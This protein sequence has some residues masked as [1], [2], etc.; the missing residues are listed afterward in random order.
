MFLNGIPLAAAALFLLLLSSH[1]FAQNCVDIAVST[2]DVMLA[3]NE[4]MADY[5][6]LLNNGSEGTFVIDGVDA[7]ESSAFLSASYV[8]ADST[9]MEPYGS[10]ELTIRLA[11]SSV[12]SDQTTAVTVGVRGHFQGGQSCSS[13]QIQSQFEVQ[14]PDSYSPTDDSQ[15]EEEIAP[16]EDGQQSD[17][18]TQAAVA[19]T[20][21]GESN[22]AVSAAIL[23]ALTVE[24]P[25][26]VFLAKGEKEISIRMTNG[27]ASSADYSIDFIGPVNVSF[28][29]SN[30]TIGAFSTKYITMRVP[31]SASLAG[32]DYEST[33][34]VQS[35]G[36]KIEKKIDV[37]FMEKAA[38]PAP[39]PKKDADD[40]IGSNALVSGFFALFSFDWLGW[41]GW[42]FTPE[43]AL[44]LA[45]ALIAAVLLIAF[46]A[47]FVKRLE[48]KK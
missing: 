43:N 21:Y 41:F 18:S 42:L 15:A 31:Y 4:T 38:A 44:N 26:N 20:Y 16:G 7:A 47:R 28:S 36:E 46:I 32:Q 45:L 37:S 48:A 40:F 25:G 35:G 3:E 24:A 13:A 11:A 39:V 22:S 1:A 8:S 23:G 34:L 17:E 14:V 9:T 12:E 2:Y 29:G 10:A 30:G 27:S 19:T 5:A 33:L 6:A